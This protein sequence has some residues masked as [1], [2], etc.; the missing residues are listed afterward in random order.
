M[1]NS[2][3]PS[4]PVDNLSLNRSNLS[5]ALATAT[6]HHQAGRL[7][8]AE[9]IYRQILQQQPQQVEV[10]NLL[11]VIACQ[12]G[13]LEEGIALYRQA[14]TIKPS[15]TGARENLCLALWKL[16][17][18]MIEE[19]IANYSQIA[20]F[21][22]KNL[23]AYD[24]LGAIFQDQNKLD[25]A[26]TYYQQALIIQPEEPQTLNNI[27]V[28]L[29]R[30]GKVKTA[31]SFHQRALAAQ[32]NCGEAHISLGT[33]LHEQGKF[34]EAADCFNR[35]L[36]LAPNN[37][38]AHY[39]RGLLLLIQGNYQEGFAEYEWRLHTGEFPPCPFKQPVWDGSHLKGRTL[40]LH[41]E[42]GLGDTI[43]FIRYAPIIAQK[44]GR[45]VFT[46]HKPLMRLMA[47][48]PGIDQLVPLGFPLPEFH[49]YA[50]LLSLP[51]ILG[52]TLETVPNAVPYLHPPA[53]NWHLNHSPETQLKVGIVWSGGNLYKRNQVRSCPLIH[54]QPLF[55]IPGIV[56]YSLQKGIP[57]VD[58]L[59][60]SDE[61]QVQD[62]SNQLNDMADTATAI[63][64]LDLVITVDTSIAHLAG[65]L[66][67]PVWTLLSY[68]PD[69]RWLLHR[70][71]TPWY[72]TMRLFRQ[73]HPGDWPG[74]M[75]KVEQALKESIK[76]P[77][78]LQKPVDRS[79]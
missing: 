27:G 70:E 28:I 24:G 22:P 40:L 35:A 5:E 45:I 36:Q 48:I 18:Q 30:Q 29:Q 19:A 64:Q 56:Y 52:T 25:E 71:D 1:L 50:P 65:A 42:Q 31:I 34:A 68:V 77:S 37:P 59:E 2:P 47:T 72:P 8:Q 75:N 26:L 41:A 62:L 57:Q 49:T 46:C 79:L 10:L 73:N 13:Q 12:K 44:G 16:G 58:L 4:L 39:N 69:W 11:G 61:T 33:A 60:L 14:L 6:A 76:N 23:K 67:K 53:S 54:F 20:N 7:T 32:P 66:G 38:N 3:S 63:A 74:V 9:Q 78:H 21:E 51:H 43:Q 15:F 55:N 17:R